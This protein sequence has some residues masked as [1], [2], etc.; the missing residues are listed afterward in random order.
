M[1]SAMSMTLMVTHADLNTPFTVSVC[2]VDQFVFSK[3]V[4]NTC[5]IAVGLMTLYFLMLWG[6]VINICDDMIRLELQGTCEFQ[7]N[8]AKK[9]CIFRQIQCMTVFGFK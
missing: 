9:Y 5:L 1:L 7:V 6:E 4:C 8:L 2:V 3:T